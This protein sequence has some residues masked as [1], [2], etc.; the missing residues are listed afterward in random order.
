MPQSI[1]RKVILAAG[2]IGMW[3]FG[4]GAALSPSNAAHAAVFQAASVARPHVALPPLSRPGPQLFGRC[5][6]PVFTFFVVFIGNDE[7]VE[8]V[9]LAQEQNGLW[10]PCGADRVVRV[11]HRRPLIYGW[12]NTIATVSKLA[13]G[14]VGCFVTADPMDNTISV[15][16]VT[17]KA[18]TTI[19]N[20]STCSGCSPVSV[21]ADAHG[22]IYASIQGPASLGTSYVYIYAPGATS[23]TTI[24]QSPQPGLTAGGI[25]VDTKRNVYWADNPLTGSYT[26]EVW[27]LAY[28]AKQ[29][30]GAPAP[31]LYATGGGPLGGVLVTQQVLV[32]SLPG[33]GLVGVETLS[34]GNVTTV[35]TGGSP[36][37]IGLDAAQD[38]LY[39]TDPVNQLISTYT[40][41]Q[42]QPTYS[43]DF[44]LRSG[45]QGVPFAATPY[46]PPKA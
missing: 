35:S 34:S 11:I 28:S 23:P 8:Y 43:G 25:A 9:G 45:K 2:L 24:L 19:A 7:I 37:S 20:L 1:V 39:V 18:Q 10:V 42:G 21:A 14:C 6:D 32:A 36:E 17:T 40:F 38:T 26:G 15:L 13:A 46:S 30:Y 12:Y 29:G 33:A 4:P 41:P 44:T 16:Q 3:T 22:Y 27:K 5:N 31:V